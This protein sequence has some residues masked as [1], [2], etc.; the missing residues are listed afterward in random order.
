MKTKILKKEEIAANII[1][2]FKEIIDC[3][4]KKTKVE[5]LSEST[6]RTYS[7]KLADIVIHFKKLPEHIL[8]DE[9]QTYFSDLIKSAKSPSR[10]EFKA[11]VYGLRYYFK[12]R[13]IK[14]HVALPI[15]K[16][17][18]KMPVVLSKQEC[19]EMICLTQ[20]LKHR[21][22]LKLIYAC[23]LRTKEVTELKWT[24]L[25]ID[26]MTLLVK[27]SKGNKDRYV[28]ISENLIE[29]LIEYT[30]LTNNCEYVFR[31][32]SIYQKMSK[33][34]IRFLMSQAVK[35]ANINKDGVSTHTLRHCFA[36]HLLEDGMDIVSIKEL[37]G[38]SS[39][40]TTLVYLH[41]VNLPISKRF[42][43]LDTLFNGVVYN[44]KTFIKNK[45][46]EFKHKKQ[47][48]IKNN[49]TQLELFEIDL[50]NQ[51]SN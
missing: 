4:D 30:K 12:M 35:R 2:D 22:I 43:P 11:L 25:D 51:L 6:F 24:H 18:R 14:K 39:I 33:S 7:R 37:L 44:D 13:G 27:R 49:F 32:K 5:G 36:S 38:H 28:P 16:K 29:D 31:G 1:S 50:V 3:L 23:G 46:Q 41:V 42:S 9:Y 10:S 21:L 17:E 40:N 26:R 8:E 34:C 45:L 47:L 48:A 20:N 19:K 15:I